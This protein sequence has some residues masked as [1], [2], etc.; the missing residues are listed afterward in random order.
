MQSAPGVCGEYSI[1]RF[2]INTGDLQ[3]CDDSSVGYGIQHTELVENAVQ[4][5]VYG[6]LH[7]HNTPRT[8][9]KYNV[10]K[11]TPYGG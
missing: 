8:L 9:H 3:E 1:D 4:G 2:S 7:I 6:V 5:A 10:R 11:C